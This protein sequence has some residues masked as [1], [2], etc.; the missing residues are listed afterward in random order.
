MMSTAVDERDDAGYGRLDRERAESLADE[1]GAS[2]IAFEARAVL[3]DGNRWP[4]PWLWA[5]GI[6]VGFLAAA[7]MARRR[8][9]RLK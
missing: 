6:S 1:G 5:A 9:M 2:A 7:V 4:R 8:R 3:P